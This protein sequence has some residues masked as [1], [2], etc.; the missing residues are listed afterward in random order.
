MSPR[1]KFDPALIPEAPDLSYEHGLWA[2][3]IRFVAGTDEAGRGALAGPVSAG[4]VILPKDPVITA[5]LHGLRDSK[6][7]SPAERDSW[8]SRLRETVLTSGVGFAS[9]QEIDVIGIVPAV[10]LAIRRALDCLSVAPE[11]LLVDF[12]TLPEITT[13]Q[14]AL[15]KGDARVLSIAAASVLAK[16][17]R[18]AQMLEL[19]LCYPGYGFASNKGY[20][21]QM[22]RDAIRVLGLSPVHRA[23]F[24]I[25]S[26][27][28]D[29]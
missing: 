16:T 25:H 20:G 3:G 7:L 24:H 8:A 26:K 2:K 17:A 28:S 14:T 27:L 29:M 9:S 21:T 18:D 6:Q 22:H 10:R 15:V 13:P 4:V 12:L 5:R 11:H 1:S 23:S 19:D